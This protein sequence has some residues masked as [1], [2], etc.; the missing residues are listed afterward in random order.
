MERVVCDNVPWL[1]AQ[2]LYSDAMK[3]CLVLPHM[4]YAM[5]SSLAFTDRHDAYL[6]STRTLHTCE[7]DDDDDDDEGEEEYNKKRL[8]S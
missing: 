1:Q 6:P 7:D 4:R 2:E 3:S 5:R 8:S